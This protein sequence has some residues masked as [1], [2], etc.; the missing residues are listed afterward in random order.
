MRRLVL[1]VLLAVASS[2]IFGQSTDNSSIQSK[3]EE[4]KAKLE[5]N[6]NQTKQLLNDRY[7]VLES[8]YLKSRHS[9]TYVVNSNLNFV[10][11]DSTNAVVQIGSN[12]GVGAN[13]VGGVTVEGKITKWKLTENPQNKSFY[14]EMSLMTK[15]GFY[16]VNISVGASGYATARLTGIGPGELTFNGYLV[17]LDN[18]RVY[19][20]ISL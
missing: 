2:F 20:G 18:S 3:K 16:D 13:G 1:I 4:R 7:F 14:L 9:F 12:Y 10:K 6:Y 19:Q 11:V 17:N 5:Q 8:D 15:V